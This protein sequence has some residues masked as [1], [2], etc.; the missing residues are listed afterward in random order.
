MTAWRFTRSPHALDL[1]GSLPLEDQL[2]L[3]DLI[4]RLE[5]NPDAATEPYG[6]EDTGPIRMRQAAIGNTIAV[7]LIN[8]TTRRITLV[9]VTHAG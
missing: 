3:F 6:I 9:Q 8:E 4:P 5:E 2:A 1:I 7:F